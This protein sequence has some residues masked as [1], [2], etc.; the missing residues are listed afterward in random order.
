MPSFSNY[1]MVDIILSLVDI[2]LV[3]FVTYRLLMI[4]RGT[5]AIQLL[6]GILII[7]IIKLVSNW[8]GLGILEEIT[9]QLINWGFLA[10]IIIFQPELRNALEQL[11]RANFF[12]RSKIVE[13]DATENMVNSLIK[14]TTYLA[15][16]RIGAL[17]TIEG[18]KSLRSQIDTGTNINA[19]IS[20]QLLINIFIPNTPL[21]DGA[22]I[23]SE[24]LI[25]AA[26]CY[27]PLSESQI[28]SKELGTRH[29]AA[30][31]ISEETDSLTIIVSEETGDISTAKHG[32]LNR[33]L[34]EEE[35]KSILQNEITNNNASSNKT[36]LKWGLKRN[37]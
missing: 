30:I 10:V 9:D 34:K 3:W 28:I 25:A 4:V 1:S 23:I 14:T 29:R 36:L 33:G 7:I 27:L 16:R 32:V 18:E 15:K 13:V 2:S 21:H 8:L 12:K 19:E 17:I 24:G 31:G 20:A 11:G 37:G 6:K 5:K 22:V 35:L 26:G